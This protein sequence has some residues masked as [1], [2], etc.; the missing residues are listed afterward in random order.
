M[1]LTTVADGLAAV[2]VEVVLGRVD[3][4]AE[5]VDVV[6]GRVLVAIAVLVVRRVLRPVL[7]EEETLDE[8]GTGTLLGATSVD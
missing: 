5:R 2:E 1:P 3:V 6:T 4:V 8:T 7:L